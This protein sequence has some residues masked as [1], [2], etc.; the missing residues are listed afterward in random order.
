[1]REAETH[2]IFVPDESP[3]VIASFAD[4]VYKGEVYEIESGEQVDLALDCWKLGDKWQMPDWQDNLVNAIA[5]YWEQDVM[6]ISHVRWG[7]KECPYKL[8]S[9]F[10]K[11]TFKR[12]LLRRIQ[13]YQKDRVLDIFIEEGYMSLTEILLALQSG[14]MSRRDS[15]TRLCKYHLHLKDKTVGGCPHVD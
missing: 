11:D 9:K 15:A 10:I 12:T 5:D 2:V 7:I 13:C 4:W 3:D 14:A 1:M 6:S 8:L